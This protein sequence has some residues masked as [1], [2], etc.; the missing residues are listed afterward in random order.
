[1]AA[2]GTFQIRAQIPDRY[3]PR[4]RAL[5]AEDARI[6][7]LAED[8]ELPL[9]RLAADIKPGRSGIDA[10]FA[11]PGTDRLPAIGR[12]MEITVRLPAQPGLVALPAQAL[13]ENERIYTVSEG[14]LRAIAVERIG[15]TLDASGAYQILIRSDGALVGQ[16]VIITALPRAVDGLL[17]EPLG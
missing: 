17:V 11:F 15:E 6:S 13:Y 8:V 7:A 3:A 4:M 5:L 2:A 1:M 16:Q 9:V 12:V 10:F 14:R